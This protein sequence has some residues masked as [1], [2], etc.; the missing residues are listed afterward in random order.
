[1][2]SF[3]G[4]L[5]GGDERKGK[6]KSPFVWQNQALVPSALPGF[7]QG[8]QRLGA[9]TPGT[10]RKTKHAPSPRID[11]YTLFMFFILNVCR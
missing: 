11:T 7:E 10:G 3:E 5:R 6:K 2:F 1:L 4:V 9:Q 8:Q